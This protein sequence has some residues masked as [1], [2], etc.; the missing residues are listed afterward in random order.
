ME[1]RCERFMLD[2]KRPPDA[3]TPKE[4]AKLRSVVGSW[5]GH[6]ISLGVSC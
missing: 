3:K 5:A 1:A 2:A 4:V 6:G